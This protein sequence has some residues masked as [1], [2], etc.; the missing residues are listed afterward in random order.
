MLN[1]L[2]ECCVCHVKKLNCVPC[3]NIGV[4]GIFNKPSYSFVCRDCYNSVNN[5]QT[6]LNI[7]K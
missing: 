7:T 1:I 4:L 5:L 2:Q 3:G 6:I